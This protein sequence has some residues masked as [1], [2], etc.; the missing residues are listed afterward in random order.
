MY[1]GG[2]VLLAYLC[3]IEEI[4]MVKIYHFQCGRERELCG[5]F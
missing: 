1:K 5:A 2:I 3:K 4:F